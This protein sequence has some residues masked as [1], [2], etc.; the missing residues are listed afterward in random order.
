MNNVPS[1]DRN[2]FVTTY[3]LGHMMVHQQKNKNQQKNI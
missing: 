2:G 3:A 1:G